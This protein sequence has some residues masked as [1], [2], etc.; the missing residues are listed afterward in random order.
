LV[1]P[2]WSPDGRRLCSTVGSQGSALLDLTLPLEQR[3]PK[4]LRPVRNGVAL[5]AT[6]WSPDG[7]RLAG[8]DPSGSGIGLYTLDT[9]RYEKLT[10]NGWGPVWLP[11]SRTLLYLDR[12]DV[13]A[14]DIATRQVSTVLTKSARSPY[15]A[16]CVSRDGRSLYVTRETDEAD[17]WMLALQGEAPVVR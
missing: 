4:L 11:D 6:A 15:G 1:F 9:G 17:I 2:I 8:N 7:K 13:F 14:A 10:E 5:F 3:L 12:G 16:L